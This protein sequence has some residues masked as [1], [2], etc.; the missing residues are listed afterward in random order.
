MK[1]RFAE[2]A[3]SAGALMS[4]IGLVGMVFAMAGGHVPEWV[5]GVAI[6]HGAVL[7]GCGASIGFDLRRDS[8]G[9]LHEALERIRAVRH[10]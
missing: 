7:M 9:E 8:A 2:V 5:M 4:T 6:I 3:L 10:V 1:Q